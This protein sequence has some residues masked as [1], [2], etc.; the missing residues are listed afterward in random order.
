MA[1]NFNGVDVIGAINYNGTSL[2][3]LKFNN[4]SVWGKPFGLTITKGANTEVVVNRTSSPNQGASTGNLSS[5][6]LIYYGD[7]LQISVTVASGYNLSS[8]TLN[9]SNWT[10]GSSH[11]VSGA[12]EVVS[13]A[14]V[15]K[16]WKTVWT[17]NVEYSTKSGSYVSI[18]KTISGVVVGRPTRVT[19]EGFMSNKNTSF[20]NV[21]LSST[22]N[23]S[24]VKV[25]NGVLDE[26]I[27]PITSSNSITA[28]IGTAYSL[29]SA[30]IRLTQVQ[31]YY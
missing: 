15:A 16:S 12:V 30:G 26:Y 17:G 22:A 18:S 24:V 19:G 9:G 1:L 20:N 27:Q 23:T 13:S 8:F 21:E 4:T 6:S 2:N 5:G 28:Y 10:S 7:V 3:V 14:V 25:G 31:Q 11:T 29:F